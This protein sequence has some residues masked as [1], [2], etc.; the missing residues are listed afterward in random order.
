MVDHKQAYWYAFV[1][2][3]R[4]EKKVKN[5]L[6]KKG[7]VNYLPVQRT[8][9]QWKDRRRWVESPLF[10]CYIFAHISYADRYEVLTVPSVVRQVGFGNK[11]AP[12]PAE[13]IESIK[14]ILN[15]NQNVTVIDGKVAGDRVRIL[16]GPLAGMEG[17]LVQFRGSQC[18]EI[19]LE[20]IG[21]SILVDV[22]D[23]QVK[24]V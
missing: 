10:S 5:Y 6:D 22:R 16:S 8:L 7:L 15:A 14:T 20:T 9:N 18:F 4:H 19:Y 11:P 13:D 23:N 12:V 17:Q 3:P 21:K 1:T 24:K 2:R